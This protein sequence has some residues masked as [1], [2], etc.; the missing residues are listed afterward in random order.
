VSIAETNLKENMEKWYIEGNSKYRI[1]WSSSGMDA[2]VAV[3]IKKEINKYI[4]NIKKFEGRAIA[5]DL[6][7]PRKTVIRFIQVYFPSKKSE[8][9]DLITQVDTWCAEARRKKYKLI[10]ASDFNAVPSPNIDRNNSNTSDIPECEI[11][12]LMTGKELTDS[13]R[14]IYPEKGG[15][16]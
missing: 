3:I 8:R 10:V 15:Y 9:V 12:S 5:L 14:I 11:F 2:G 6:V 7:L 13:Y 4:C 16:T 1:H